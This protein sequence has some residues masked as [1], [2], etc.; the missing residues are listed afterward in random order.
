LILRFGLSALNET[1]ISRLNHVWRRL[2]PWPDVKRGLQRLRQ[3]YVV[4]TLSNGN[5]AL[6]THMARHAGLHWDCILS[7]ELFHHYKPDPE[8]YLGAARLLDLAPHQVMMVAAHNQD[9]LAARSLGL[10]TAFIHR[11]KEYGPKQAAD[12][13][14]DSDINIEA[15]D[16]LDLADQLASRRGSP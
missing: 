9:L 2:T 6:L 15:R 14:P 4:A 10:R 3:R 11:P 16:L 5:I 13:I 8:V 7:A 12:L 1:E